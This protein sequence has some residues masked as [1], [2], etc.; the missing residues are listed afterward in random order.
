M[1][2]YRV[3]I[4]LICLTLTWPA[5]AGT[6]SP[7]KPAARGTTATTRNDA[8][9]A[10]VRFERKW[11]PKE[12][13]FSLLV[14]A[15]WVMEG[16][17][18]HVNPVE[19]NGPGNSI[20]AKCNLTVKKDAAGAVYFRWLPT[21]NYADMSRSPQMSAA[22]G[23][24]PP[25]SKYGGMEV[26]PMPDCASFLQQLFKSL[27]PAATD[28][29]VVQVKP[30]PELAEGFSRLFQPVDDQLR[31][32]GVAPLRFDAGGL[33]VDY[34]EGQQRFREAL[35]TCLMDFRSAAMLWS[36]LYTL[37][38]RA[39]VGEAE[40]W[41][42]ILE[43]IRQSTRFNPQWVAAASKAAGERGQIVQDTMKRLQ[44]I[45]QEIFANR[46]KTN[47]AIQQENYLLLTSQEEYVNPFTQEIERDT[48]DYKYRWTTE[49]GD[50]IYT[51]RQDFNPNAQQEINQQAWK[52]T[53]ARPR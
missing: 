12:R 33:V 43:I 8:E 7:A 5:S 2:Q 19:M 38:L 25:G 29:T 27:H 35:V 31:P 13:A 24:F 10:A 28:V 3:S 15:G 17:M 22:A 51:D 42:P 23:M 26:R 6:S 49:Q 16:G 18:F 32:L 37:A 46:S 50:M 40:R 53:P 48:S 20:D 44:T 47:A 39:P 45:D 36:N 1:K 34:S 30:I 9:P 52:L 21:W 11:E 14:P 4:D 41:K